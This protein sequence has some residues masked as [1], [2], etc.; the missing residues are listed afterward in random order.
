MEWLNRVDGMWWGFGMA[1]MF[2]GINSARHSVAC[3]INTRK[4][5]RTEADF[6]LDRAE[7]SLCYL[8]VG[9]LISLIVFQLVGGTLLRG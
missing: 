3:I 7:I 5:L 6:S 1:L 9:V 8:I 2:W 4:G